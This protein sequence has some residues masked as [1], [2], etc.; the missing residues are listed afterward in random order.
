MGDRVVGWRKVSKGHRCLMG[1][2]QKMDSVTGVL[3]Y[4]P[5]GWP[6]VKTPLMTIQLFEYPLATSGIRPGRLNIVTSPF[7]D[8]QVRL[9]HYQWRALRGSR[10]R[11]V[12][13]CMALTPTKPP[14]RADEQTPPESASA[15]SFC[16]SWSLRFWFSAPIISSS[17]TM[18]SRV[19]MTLF[20]LRLLGS[21]SL[22][23]LLITVILSQKLHRHPV[24]LNFVCTSIL[25]SSL[26]TYLCAV[27][28]VN[29]LQLIGWHWQWYSG[30]STS[31]VRCRHRR[32]REIGT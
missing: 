17:S 2:R 1:T 7:T 11:K 19:G 29:E 3:L 22:S 4:S 20:A 9:N 6:S 13:N 18:L 10:G 30:Y 24:F 31:M 27:I 28:L 5:F 25:Y 32:G 16:L 26:L 15:L 8:I 14:C 21:V 12:P 23:A